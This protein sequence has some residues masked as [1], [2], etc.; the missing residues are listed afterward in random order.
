MDDFISLPRRWPILLHD[1]ASAYVGFWACNY[2]LLCQGS[3]FKLGSSKNLILLLFFL[4]FL[5]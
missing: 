1:I 4:D 3:S 5:M 2:E